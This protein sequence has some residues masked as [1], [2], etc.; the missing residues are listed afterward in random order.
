MLG[1]NI[2][3]DG[4]YYDNMG[5]GTTPWPACGEIDIMEHWGNNQNYVQSATHTPSSFGGTINHG[6][7]NIPTASSDFHVYALDWYPDK[8]VFS[9]DSIVHYTYK[10]LVQDTAT[11]PFTADQFILLNTAIQ[12]TIDPGFR[13][14]TM[15]ID[16]VRVYQQ[17]GLSIDPADPISG[18]ILSPNPVEDELHITLTEAVNKPVSID[19]YN[20]EGKRVRTSTERVHNK[21]I[22]LRQLEQLP[23]GMYMLSYELNDKKYSLKFLRK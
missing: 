22:V 13:E 9:V 15:E 10:P 1:K 21:Q 4:A 11:W 7:R 2:D 14:S 20:M 17:F 16:Y 6:G 8:L 19:I 12:P 23:S 3:E 5:L 18:P